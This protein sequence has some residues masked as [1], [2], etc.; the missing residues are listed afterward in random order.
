MIRSGLIVAIVLAS[1]V[2]MAQQ[3]PEQSAKPESAVLPGYAA[4]RGDRPLARVEDMGKLMFE[5]YPASARRN[6]IEGDVTLSMCVSAEGRATDVKLIKSSGNQA[7][8]EASVKGMAKVRFSPGRNAE[9][10]PI[11]WCDPPHVLTMAWRLP[12]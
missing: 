8:D 2:A 11:D 6:R 9:G 12:R 5:N 3:I 10:K 7:L 4:G 1:G